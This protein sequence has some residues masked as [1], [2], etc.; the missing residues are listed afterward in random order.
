[1]I[2]SNQTK[3][4]DDICD[5]ISKQPGIRFCGIVNKLGRLIAGGFKQDI[6]PY[7]TDEKNRTIYMQLCLE[8]SM[9]KEY[10]DLLGPIEYI[11]AKRKKVTM[12]SIPIQSYFMILSVEPFVDSEKIVKHVM[13][14]FQENVY[15]KQ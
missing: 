8:L 1:M 15:L 2:T 12:I 5:T 7:V 11:A 9:R 4:L 13:E 3:I 10:D 14:I 6:I